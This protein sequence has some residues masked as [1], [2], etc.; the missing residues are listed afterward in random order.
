VRE[1]KEAIFF[2]QDIPARNTKVK[3][4]VMWD[5]GCYRVLIRDSF[6]KKS[7]LVS[8][9]VVY[10]MEVVGDSKPKQIKSRIY[11]LDLIDMYGNIHSIWGYGTPKIM[12]SSI[13]DLSVIRHLFPH[14]PADAFMSLPSKEV[15][16]L[17]GLNMN[18]LQPAGGLGTDRV[19]GL[20]ALRSLF[21]CGWVVGGHHDDIR[22]TSS[23]ISSAAAILKVAKILIEPKPPLTPEFWESEG[24]GVFPPPRCDH[25]KNCMERGPSSE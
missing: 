12:T 13:P 5:K 11:L 4:R 23:D 7:N 22:N 16:V 9:E 17:I 14:V 2:V 3:P 6:A 8:K 15:D 25:C 21:G 1:N 19:K 20:S 10:T 24:L 18:E